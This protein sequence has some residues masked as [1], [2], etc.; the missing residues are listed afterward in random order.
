MNILLF[1]IFLLIF[2]VEDWDDPEEL[3]YGSVAGLQDINTEKEY[4][5]RRIATYIINLLSIGFSGIMIENTRHIPNFSM[6][7]I[8]GYTKEYLGNKLPSDFLI[9]LIIEGLSVDIAMCDEGETILDFGNYFIKFLKNE[10]FKDYEILQIKFWFKGC[11]AYDEFLENYTPSCYAERDEDLLFDVK[12]WTIS[13]EYSDDI[14]MGHDDYNIYIRSKNKQ[15]HKNILINDMFLHPRFNY[16]IRFIFTSY[17][18]DSV[19]GVPDGKSEKSFCSSESC[20][21]YIIDLPY[22]RAFNPHSTGYDCGDR[23]NWIIC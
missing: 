18:I 22:R 7:K 10:G 21:Q 13:L 20:L 12:R 19:N 14:N 1:L 6:A 8:L 15:E 9:I 16:S 4:P 5:R 11:L 3:C 17:S 23:N 2:I